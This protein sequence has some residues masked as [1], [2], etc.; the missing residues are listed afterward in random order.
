MAL[1]VAL[2]GFGRIGRHIFR[3]HYGNPD[4]EIVA[5]NDLFPAEIMAYLLKYDSVYKTW[6]QDIGHSENAL[7]IN[8]KTVAYSSIRSLEELPWGELGIDLVIEATGVFVKR[9]DLDKHLAHG[10]K[11]VV[12]T[13][14][15]KGDG[16]DITIVLGCNDDKYDPGKHSIISNASCTTNCFAPMVKVI[17]EN[18]GIVNG[19]MTTIHSYTATQSLL[20]VAQKDKRR[21]RAAALNLVPSSTG[22]ARAIGLIFPEMVGKLD[23]MAFRVPVPTVSS[24]DF[25]CNIEKPTTAEDVNKAFKTAA[26]G[27]LKGILAYIDDE[28]V[29]GDFIG[30]SHSCSFDATST[31]MIGDKM[32]KTIGWYDNEWGYSSRMV[33]LVSMIAGKWS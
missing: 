1:R 29:S 13:A 2:N 28:L 21:S 30:D 22:A 27:P 3:G 26:K 19:L 18:H 7:I 5:I 31:L 9:V 4:F 8:G 17:N 12:L 20:D 23:A 15:G 25:V 24:V 10:P 14:P 33:D 32:L 6:D 16:P 11:K